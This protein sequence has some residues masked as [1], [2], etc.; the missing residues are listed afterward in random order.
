MS[1][2]PLAVRA[3]RDD[4]GVALTSFLSGLS[5]TSTRFWHGATSAADAAA[6]W[7]EA[8]GRYDK[9][10]LVA[11]HPDRPAEF[12]GVVDLSF[13]LPVEAELSRYAGYGI[14]LDENRTVRFGPC[15]ADA[16]QGRGLAAHL[17][18]PAWDAARLFGRDCVVLFGGVHADNH[19]ARRFYQR[20]GFTEVG[21]FSNTDGDCIDMMRHLVR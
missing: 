16:W 18:P 11:H 10:R 9:L 5:P 17:L 3:L 14:T 20:H 21:A 6:D 12:A 7:I 13:S 19:R 1:G 8:I 2:T 15:V 4:D